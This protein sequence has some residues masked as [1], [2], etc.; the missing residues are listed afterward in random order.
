MIHFNLLQEY[1][2]K[3][4]C[5]HTLNCAVR[6]QSHHISCAGCLILN[7]V[8]TG[9]P[10]HPISAALSKSEPRRKLLVAHH[11]LTTS[12]VRQL[13]WLQSVCKRLIRAVFGS[14]R[15]RRGCGR[16]WE[17]MPRQWWGF[18]GSSALCVR[19]HFMSIWYHASV[20]KESLIAK[21]FSSLW[22]EKAHKGRCLSRDIMYKRAV[23]K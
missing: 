15:G 19:S 7:S 4:N 3:L 16:V 12:G 8:I 5:F 10:Q 11:C 23:K 20:S 2:P 1:K 13:P 6:I 14:N 18:T 17:Y 9:V 22:L 21:S